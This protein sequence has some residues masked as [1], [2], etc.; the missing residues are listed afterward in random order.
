[1]ALGT[2]ILGATT[3]GVGLLVGGI[4]F[5]VTGTK[6]SEKAD[7]AYSQASKTEK[8]VDEI[9]LYLSRLENSA[10]SFK[11]TL[12]S[13]EEEYKK[14][15]QILDHV[16]NYEGKTDWNE[17]SAKDQKV[18]ENTVLLVG[19]LYKMCQV[20]LVIKNKDKDAQNTINTKAIKDAELEADLLLD[21]VA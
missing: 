18:T 7:E 20:Q 8:E 17:F 16:I 19:M 10:R 15:M 12:T 6:L 21:N 4:I 14:H 13:V 2:T 3:L 11:K 9:C 1:M 5:N